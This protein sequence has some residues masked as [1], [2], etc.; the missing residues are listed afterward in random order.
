MDFKLHKVD[1]HSKAR[2]GEIN[3]LHGKVPTPIF[4]PVGTQGTVKSLTPEHLRDAN[5]IAILCN[6]YHL[7]LRPGEDIV[8]DCGGLHK[9]IGWDRP[10][11][12]DSGGYQVFSLSEFAKI[13]DGGVEFKS[14]IDGS[15]KFL[16]P[17]KATN[18]QESLGADIIMAFDEC[19]AY[20]CEKDVAKVA[21][22]R[23]IRWAKRCLEAHSDKNQALFGI[24]QGSV[25]KDLRLECA[26]KLVELDFDGYSIGGLSVGEGRLLMNEVLDYVACALPETK[27]RYLMGVGFPID[28]LDAVE[29]GVD[30]FDCII[31]TRNGRNGCAFTNSGKK[32]VFNSKYKDL[33]APIDDECECYACRNFSLAYIRHLFNA[34]EILGLTL[35]SLHNISFFTKMMSD[36]RLAIMEDNFLQFKA[37]FLARMN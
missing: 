23:T 34:K 14:P 12:T 9:F 17:E 25:F 3:T 18:I 19:V 11:I 13:S 7:S 36:A 22:E 24:V 15:V 28:I 29:R 37:D 8:K 30:M 1:K 16:S 27:P 33:D 10:I 20:P 31:P 5:A 26:E 32:N 2:L 6:T 35:L 21:M 4:M